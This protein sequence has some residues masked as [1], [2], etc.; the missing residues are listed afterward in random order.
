M[1]NFL[2][3]VL[4]PSTATIKTIDTYLTRPMRILMPWAADRYRFGGE[5][6]GAW[7][8]AT[9]PANW[10]P[11]TACSA[12]GR[13]AGRPCDECGDAPRHGRPPG[14]IVVGWDEWAAHPGDLVPLTAL[15]DPSW[16]FP[17]GYRPPSAAADVRTG[18][19]SPDLWVDN[20]DMQWLN[21]DV[22]HDG[23][24]TGKLPA[25]L[26]DILRR[27]RSGDRVADQD[28]SGAFAP[29]HWQVAIVAG[30]IAPDDAS[31]DMPTVGSVVA[32]TD[33][34]HTD[35]DAAPDQLYVVTDDT[36]RPYYLLA[37][38]GGGYSRLIPGYAITEVDPARVALAAVPDGTPPYRRSQRREPR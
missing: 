23:A 25:D 2:V 9:D 27:L 3:A 5:F 7:D 38:L 8:P 6:T 4:V 33:P 21:L 18:G 13:T 11:C 1:S 35:D 12:T 19:A 28:H 10:R 15:L 34:D 32:V 14:T 26:R 29:K 36:D 17:T 31:L 24:L 16:R 20:A 37:R 30:H 22:T